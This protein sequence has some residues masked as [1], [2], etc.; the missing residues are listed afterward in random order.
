MFFDPSSFHE[1]KH[2]M[3]NFQE[4]AGEI[5][6]SYFNAGLEPTECLVKIAQSEELTPHHV[7]V[8]ATETN[9][10]I[11]Q[12]KYASADNKYHAADFPLADAKIALARLQTDGGQEKTAVAMPDPVVSR[13]E[14]DPFE[15]FGIKEEPM[16]KTASVRSDLKHH[17]ARAELLGQKLQDQCILTKFAAADA[18]KA[19]IKE[20]RQLVLAADNSEE[21]MKT[22]G[23]LDHFT[24]NANM[25]DISRKPLAKL[26]Y[27]LSKE[28][29]LEASQAKV[30]ME[31]FMSKNADEKAPQALISDYLN[32]RVVNGNHPLYITLK[33]FQDSSSAL[34]VNKDRYQI[35]DDRLRCIKQKIRA[36]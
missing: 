35:V 12:Q 16:D 31:Y 33:T 34:D 11:H 4:W 7:H 19:F 14:V 2:S 1:P 6:S 22:L 36:L 13:Q 21:R 24:K 3:D 27:V 29:L 25:S 18:E 32:A 5:A 10:L 30:A 20:A 28:G 9:K 17:G 8:L 26:A 15:M 23:Y